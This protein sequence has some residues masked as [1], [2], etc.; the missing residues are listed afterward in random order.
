MAR[1]NGGLIKHKLLLGLDDRGKLSCHKVIIY[2]IHFTAAPIK[3]WNIPE[4]ILTGCQVNNS[5]ETLVCRRQIF[6][7]AIPF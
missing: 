4:N 6:C 3:L 2:F 7:R 5:V 1:V